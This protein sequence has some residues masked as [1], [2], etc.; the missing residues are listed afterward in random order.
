MMGS[1]KTW[2]QRRT[3]AR[4]S[5][6]R[7]DA[8][9]EV[10][11]VP[12]KGNQAVLI[13]EKPRCTSILASEPRIFFP[14]KLLPTR[15]THERTQHAACVCECA[16]R[17]LWGA[18]CAVQ[19]HFHQRQTTRGTRLPTT[20][21]GYESSCPALPEGCRASTFVA[22]CSG[23]LVQKK[24]TARLEPPP[25]RGVV[26]RDDGRD[27]LHDAAANHGG[28]PCRVRRQHHTHGCVSN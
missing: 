10:R 6:L 13:K 12:S 20:S 25:R 9:K 18:C 22:F 7:C 14:I 26:Q 5:A 2:K 21:T 24:E 19:R 1:A 28:A 16:L 3:N 27:P 17:E 23:Q 8:T 15:P 11:R 4:W